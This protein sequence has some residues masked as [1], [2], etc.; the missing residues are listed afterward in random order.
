LNLN[1]EPT[2]PVL[3]N[4]ANR[5]GYEC[6]GQLMAT[7]WES[8]SPVRGDEIDQQER[9]QREAMLAEFDAGNTDA[10]AA[11]LAADMLC[12]QCVGHVRFHCLRTLLP[13]GLDYRMGRSHVA[14]WRPLA[15]QRLSRHLVSCLR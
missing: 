7:A 14:Y 2:S 3:T 13:R 5:D 6:V 12:Y 10:D 8:G 1:L 4:L 15:E 9:R 11:G